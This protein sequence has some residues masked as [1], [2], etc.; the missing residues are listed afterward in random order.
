[1]APRRKVTPAQTVR[2]K[3]PAPQQ[4]EVVLR[5]KMD[6]K[7]VEEELAETIIGSLYNTF[8]RGYGKKPGVKLTVGGKDIM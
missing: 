8:S 5:I 3:K 7:F 6:K 2:R 4:T 1:M